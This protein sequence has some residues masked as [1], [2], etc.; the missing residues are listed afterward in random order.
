MNNK[1]YTFDIDDWEVV[2]DNLD[3]PYIESTHIENIYNENWY[4]II[5]QKLEQ[6]NV[7]NNKKHKKDVWG[8]KNIKEIIENA[9]QSWNNIILNN[10]VKNE[11]IQ[12]NHTKKRKIS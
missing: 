4:D 5:N 10:N 6:L 7:N 2:S 1:S 9:K 3:K 11:Y 8:D 12:N